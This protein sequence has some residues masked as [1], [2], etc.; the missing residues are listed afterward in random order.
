MSNPIEMEW[1]TLRTWRSMPRLRRSPTL[2]PL[3][4][5]TRRAEIISPLDSVSFCRSALVETSVTLA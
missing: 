3:A 1:L 4:S 5:T 2:S